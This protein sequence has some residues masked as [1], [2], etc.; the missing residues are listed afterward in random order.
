MEFPAVKY[1]H[2]NLIVEALM[3]KLPGN[4]SIVSVFH[5][6]TNAQIRLHRILRLAT[7][8][9]F[10]GH[11]AWGIITKSGWV[12]YFTVANIPEKTAY[13]LMPLIGTLDI[14]LGILILILPIRAAML[15]MGIWAVW[16]ALLRPLAHVPAE[17][18][19]WEVLERAGNY[20]VPFSLLFL[21]GV[22]KD[23]KSW[24]GRIKEP[25]L[26]Q[27]RAQKLE[28]FLRITT[29]L[30][31][32]GH[33]GFEAFKHKPMLIDH[34]RAIGL[35]LGNFDPILFIT[36]VGWFEI[37]LGVLVLIKPLRPILIFIFVWKIGTELLYPIHGPFLWNIFEFIERAGSYGA[38][39]ALFYLIGDRKKFPNASL[40]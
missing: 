22:T 40:T 26:T 32:I 16:T 29:A 2:V 25:V 14:S 4:E 3:E 6:Q 33:G 24:F 19:G 30:I 11:G 10:I 35:P 9:C 8:F 37:L 27:L 38:P 7:A 13:H 23:I 17:A 34:W 5:E 39:L 31:V 12:P 21:S 15:Y 18:G 20:G 1:C 36:L 28:W